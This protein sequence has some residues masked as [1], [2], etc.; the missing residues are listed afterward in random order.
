MGHGGINCESANQG[1]GVFQRY[2]GLSRSVICRLHC[3]PAVS[4][5]SF[6]GIA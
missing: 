6:G 5:E 4:P 1:V 2:S 3:V